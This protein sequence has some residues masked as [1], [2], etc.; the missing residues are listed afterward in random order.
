PVRAIGFVLGDLPRSLVGHERVARVVDA[1][2]YLEP[3]RLPLQGGG[4][5]HLEVEHVEL[6]VGRGRDRRRVL[7]DVSLV[8]APGRTLAVVGSTGAGKSTLVDVLM[9]LTD[10]DDG[11]VRYDSVDVRALSEE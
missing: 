4:G 8:V 9:R 5:L 7:D 3:G 1:R 11:V 10:P 6:G 2:G